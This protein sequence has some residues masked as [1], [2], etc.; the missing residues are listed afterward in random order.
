MHLHS[1]LEQK[2]K[3]IGL[4]FTLVATAFNSLHAEEPIWAPEMNLKVKVVSNVDVSPEGDEVIYAVTEARI[5]E[6]FNDYF[7]QVWKG[8]VDDQST[9]TQF[10]G[11]GKPSSYPRWSPNGK[12]IAFLSKRSGVNNLYL[13]P[14]DGGEAI[15]ITDLD[16]GVES[17][18][19][20]PDGSMIAFVAKNSNACALPIKANLVEEVEKYSKAPKT[21][22]LFVIKAEPTIQIPEIMTPGGFHVIGEIDFHTVL[23]AFDWSPDNRSIAFTYTPEEGQDSRW[24]DSQIAIVDIH[25]KEIEHLP[26]LAPHQSIPHFSPD[27]KF[28]AFLKSDN[29]SLFALTRHVTL[30]SL[31]DEKFIELPKTPDEASFLVGPSILGWS[32]DGSSVLYM[33]PSR[34]KFAIWRIPIDGGEI[35]RVDDGYWTFN[36]PV[37]SRNGKWLGIPLETSNQPCEAY[38]TSTKSYA[39]KQVSDVNEELKLWTMPR[40]EI[41]RW[42]SYDGTEIEGMLTYPKNYLPGTRYPLLLAVHG[43]PMSFYSDTYLGAFPIYPL[44][45]FA[46]TG[47]V[48]LRANPRGS[49]GYGREFRHAVMADWGGCDFRDLMA[50]VD[51]LIESGITDSKR[52]GV[53]GWSYGGYMTAWIIGQTN[54]FAAASMGAG[55]SNLVSFSG[56]TDLTHFISEYFGGEVW[57]K[58]DLYM[59][60]SPISYV[61][62]VSTPLLIQHGENDDR[63]PFSQAVEFFN[64]LKK[65]KKPVELAAYPRCTH[66]LLE[67]KLGLDSLQ[68]NYNWFAD[69]VMN[70]ID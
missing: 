52:M 47:F 62:Q 12:S 8:K 2:T 35:V 17:F 61:S 59:E 1:S 63:V 39:P 50:G 42:N 4:F 20:S 32:D 41:I 60:R 70:K 24:M 67:P 46:D 3:K 36:N 27:G 34:T 10:T 23:E 6:G 28:L 30:Y 33:E 53:M 37:L 64:A 22:S 11:N 51:F 49:C 26:K 21:S 5:E 55:I 40:T 58:P 66:R 19:W 43:G 31:A 56:T 57:E 25:T 9:H 13:I 44:A 14:S 29:E 48:I 15:Q 7:T 69:K 18:R 54:R 68:R 16:D 65:V 38:V 45:S